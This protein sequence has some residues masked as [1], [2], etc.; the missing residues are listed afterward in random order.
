M[1]CS[2]LLSKAVRKERRCC[3]LKLISSDLVT[4]TTRQGVNNVPLL[5]TVPTPSSFPTPAP[6]SRVLMKAPL[7]L[8]HYQNQHHQTSSS[9]EIQI[10]HQPQHY[11]IR[12]QNP[13]TTAHVV[14]YS[15]P[16]LIQQQSTNSGPCGSHKSSSKTGVVKRVA[17]RRHA[18][19]HATAQGLVARGT[20]NPP[21]SGWKKPI[22]S[23]LGSGSF[24]LSSVVHSSSSKSSSEAVAKDNASDP[25]PLFSLPTSASN[26]PPLPET[27]GV[28]ME[29]LMKLAS[30]KTTPL[31][32]KDMYKYAIV[33]ANNREQR[34]RN[35]QFLHSE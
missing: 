6:T 15:Y 9:H 2:R 8:R 19:T 14:E 27:V 25:E 35:A 7:I 31:A 20:N 21:A 24:S 30:K 22:V 26:K 4:G 29:E 28:D 13:A 17:N 11:K 10:H 12:H 18:H 1:T 33:D 16:H 3:P 5:S 34:I 23:S 32:L